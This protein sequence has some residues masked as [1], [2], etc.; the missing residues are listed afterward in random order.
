MF[1]TWEG[2][3]ESPSL[4]VSPSPPPPTRTVPH[5]LRPRRGQA[6]LWPGVHGALGWELQLLVRGLGCGFLKG[7]RL[8]TPRLC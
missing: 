5:A 4:A 3:L 1:L 6:V 2:A 7:W 8:E